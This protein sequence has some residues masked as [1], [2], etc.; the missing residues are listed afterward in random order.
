ME[1]EE[2]LDKFPSRRSF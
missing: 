1:V 2:S